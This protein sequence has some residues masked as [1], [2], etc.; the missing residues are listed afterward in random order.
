MKFDLKK[1]RPV[2]EVVDN[3]T[4]RILRAKTGAERLDLVGTLHEMMRNR[5]LAYLGAKHPEW[6]EQQIAKEAARRISRGAL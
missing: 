6:N 1:R 3:D 4:A 5:L 2:V